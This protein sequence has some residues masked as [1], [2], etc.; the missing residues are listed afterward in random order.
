[1]KKIHYCW[2]IPL[3][4]V[5]LSGHTASGERELTKSASY[6]DST[7]RVSLSLRYGLNINAKFKGIG[8]GVLSGLGSGKNR[9]TLDGDQYNYSDGYVGNGS[10][11]R[12]DVSGN[13]LGYTSYWGYENASQYNSVANTFTFHNVTSAGIP[14]EVSGDND[15]GCPSFEFTYD[16]QL[17]IKEDWHHLRYGLGAA[18]N[19]T[20][21]SM[22]GN[23]SYNIFSTTE[24]YQFGGISGQQ[25]APGYQG[26]WSGNP[27]DPV[28]V[29]PGVS[30]SS[31]LSHNFLAQQDFDA[32]IWGFRLGPYLEY[33]FNDK[34]S[35]HLSGGLALGLID[36]EAN[37]KEK[38]TQLSDN[39]TTSASGGGRNAD[40][41]WGYYIS[42]NANYQINQRWGIEAGVQFQDLG[43]YSHNFSG[44]TAELD[45]SQS[46]FVQIGISYSF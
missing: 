21:F 18:I 33:P 5:V 24:V 28:L 15:N 16:W 22:N 3:T 30:S 40:L 2:A 14:S 19:Y 10:T 45:L 46:I 6:Q 7:N 17:G 39:S 43:T 13:F 1:M 4:G 8:N 12:A 23:N 26:L 44:R 35:L 32:N 36:A 31:S 9:V 34:W 25:P 41:L 27:G 11:L 29:V 37:W 20:R 38:L 42:L